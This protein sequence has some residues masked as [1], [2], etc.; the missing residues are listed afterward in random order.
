MNE[1]TFETTSGL[2]AL[3]HT[4]LLL[5]PHRG[6]ISADESESLFEVVPQLYLYILH[7]VIERPRSKEGAWRRG[8]G[9][10]MSWMG[11]II[12]KIKG[13]MTHNNLLVQNTCRAFRFYIFTKRA[14]SFR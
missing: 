8:E 10:E 1:C 5:C 4:P 14:N 7:Q 13:G 11:L 6:H 12:S 9:D 3:R 2:S